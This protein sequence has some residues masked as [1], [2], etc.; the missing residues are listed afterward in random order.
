[1][2][3]RHVRY[4]RN[5]RFEAKAVSS[6]GMA[7]GMM[8]VAER[9]QIRAMMGPVRAMMGP[10]VGHGPDVIDLRRGLVADLAAVVVEGEDLRSD[11]AP[12]ARRA[13]AQRVSRATR[14][15]RRPSAGDAGS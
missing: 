8:L 2:L 6:F 3:R 7:R 15:A 11:P 1:M 13:V 5:S 12:G 9:P 14:A 4:V 10:A